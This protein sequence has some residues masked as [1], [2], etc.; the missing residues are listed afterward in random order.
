MNRRTVGSEKE[1]A[2]AAYLR[3]QGYVIRQMN[4]RCRTGE[5]D[6]VASDGRYLVFVEVKYRSSGSAGGPLEAVGPKKQR[7]ISRT[8]A[9]YL[10]MH[11]LSED[12]P[13]RFDVVG[14]TGDGHVRLLKN[15]FDY[16]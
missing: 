2:A 7:Q 11:G 14:I 3:E 6:I 4:F 16:C 15:A 1:R 10:H 8:A 12:V 9:V 13:C 5:I